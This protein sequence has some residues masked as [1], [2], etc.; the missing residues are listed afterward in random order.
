M[1]TIMAMMREMMMMMVI[2]MRMRINSIVINDIQT[3]TLCPAWKKAGPP[4]YMV[5]TSDRQIVS[6]AAPPPSFRLPHLPYSRQSPWLFFLSQAGFGSG[7]EKRVG[8][9]REEVLKY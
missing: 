5:I 8:S 3:W 7:N 9:I 1:M 6:N 2:V 4:C